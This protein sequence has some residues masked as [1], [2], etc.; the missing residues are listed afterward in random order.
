M[1]TQEIWFVFESSLLPDFLVGSL[2]FG[3]LTLVD[4]ESSAGQSFVLCRSNSS[5][6]GLRLKVCPYQYRSRP[7]RFRP[8]QRSFAVAPFFQVVGMSR[9]VE[10]KLKIEVLVVSSLC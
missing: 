4:V 6:F 1:S 7:L 3:Q 10:K 2:D 9:R 8:V 5:A